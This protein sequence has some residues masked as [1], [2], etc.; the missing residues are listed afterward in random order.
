MLYTI[1]TQ[2]IL[3][4]TAVRVWYHHYYWSIKLKQLL[5]GWPV[6]KTL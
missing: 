6:N 1:M 2:Q 5:I 3:V 4:V